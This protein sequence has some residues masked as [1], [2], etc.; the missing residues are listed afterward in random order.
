MSAKIIVTQLVYLIDNQQEVF[1]QFESIALPLI[2]KYN[3]ELL[4]RIRPQAADYL[5]SAI[6]PP[7]EIHFVEF[8]TEQ[9]FQNYMH[10]EERK[11]YLHLKEKSIRA[12]VVIKGQQL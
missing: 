12:S 8:D 3:G 2:P 9:D 1:E 11:K 4:L 6:E 10:D 5:V 7:Y